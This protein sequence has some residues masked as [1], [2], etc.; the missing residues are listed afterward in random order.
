MPKAVS[1]PSSFQ[2]Y[3]QSVNKAAKLSPSSKWHVRIERL[4]K[5]PENTALKKSLKK[6]TQEKE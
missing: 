4:M 2:Y 1:L 5:G 3:L 6:Q